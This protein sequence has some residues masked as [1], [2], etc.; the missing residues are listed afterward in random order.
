[1]AG[2]LVPTAKDRE[3][4]EDLERKPCFWKECEKTFFKKG[5][6]TQKLRT[7]Q[8][9]ARRIVSILRRFA[10]LAFSGSTDFAKVA[11][12]YLQK[13]L[14]HGLVRTLQSLVSFRQARVIQI[15]FAKIG[16]L[17]SVEPRNL[18]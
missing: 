17:T 8:Q 14:S 5:F 6:L 15:F 3:K 4:Q 18:L 11:N 13:L 2:N 10:T 16:F 7:G 9:Q 1:M 12:K